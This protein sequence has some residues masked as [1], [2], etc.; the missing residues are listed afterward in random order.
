VGVG[1]V[2][3]EDVFAAVVEDIAEEADDGAGAVAACEVHNVIV[4]RG[5][6]LA[7]GAEGAVLDE[8]VSLRGHVGEV[9]QFAA[10]DAAEGAARD[11]AGGIRHIDHLRSDVCEAGIAELEI[12]VG[13]ADGAVGGGSP[14]DEAV[15]ELLGLALAGGVVEPDAVPV[16]GRTGSGEGDGFGG[17][18]DGFDAAVDGEAGARGEACGDAGFDGE[19]TAGW[20][21][22]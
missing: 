7:G 15:G 13:S 1:P 9:E 17:G 2:H 18:A 10:G 21:G 19:D 22:D 8:S 4:A 14:F 3:I 5:G 12:G 20:D 11:F 6:G 16:S